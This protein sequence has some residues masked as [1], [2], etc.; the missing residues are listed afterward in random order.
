MAKVAL[1]IGMAG[2]DG[3]GDEAIMRASANRANTKYTPEVARVICERIMAKETLTKI[4][5]DPAMPSIRT[6]I[7]WFADPERADFRDMY[8]YARRVCAEML[9]DETMD[10]L[11][12]NSE[13]WIQT[14]NKNGEPNGWKP[15]HETAANKKLRI[16]TIKWFAMKMIPRIY[17]EKLEVEHGVTGDLA[18]LIRQSSNQ[19]S[20]LPTPVND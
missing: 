17:G 8:Y 13:D 10:I 15:N 3:M 12:D 1:K 2:K 20:G 11:D 5:K 18:D 16:D 9:V 19:S 7:R 4:C 14:F 6:V